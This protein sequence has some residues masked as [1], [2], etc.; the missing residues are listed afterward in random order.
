MIPITNWIKS[1]GG[2]P[3]PK[4]Y[5]QCIRPRSYYRSKI[6]RRSAN[7]GHKIPDHT[8]HHLPIII[9]AANHHS[10]NERRTQEARTPL[11]SFDSDSF[12]ILVHCPA[13]MSLTNTRSDFI[14]PTSKNPTNLKGA[15]GSTKVEEQGIVNW[16]TEDDKGEVH[17]IQLPA[18]VNTKSP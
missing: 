1:W 14:G 17:N 5:K 6:K 3:S 9:A 7:I 11:N 4:Y 10:T 8:T 15:T 16:K 12:E 13:T 18:L 2:P